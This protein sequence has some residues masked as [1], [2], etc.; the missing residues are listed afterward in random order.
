MDVGRHLLSYLFPPVVGTLKAR[1]MP[2]NPSYLQEGFVL[3]KEEMIEDI[4]GR[5]QK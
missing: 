1:T 4:K 2:Y 5:K 3:K